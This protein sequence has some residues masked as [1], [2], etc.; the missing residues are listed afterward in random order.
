MRTLH[1]DEA[2]QGLTGRL[3]ILSTKEDIDELYQTVFLLKEPPAISLDLRTLNSRFIGS[4]LKFVE[5]YRG[6]LSVLARDPVP[7]PLQSRFT[8]IKK[9]FEPSPSE[10]ME[11]KLRNLPSGLR[12]RAYNLFNI[13][14]RTEDSDE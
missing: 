14:E 12:T 9:R 13:R 8:V 5:E 3:I 2:P 10:F 7:A 4:L 1:L 11:V 6:S